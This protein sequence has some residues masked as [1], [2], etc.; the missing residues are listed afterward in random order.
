M[1][2]VTKGLALLPRL[3]CSGAITTHCSLNLLGSS[4]PPTSASHIA[5]MTEM[6]FHYVAQAGLKLLA[7]NDSPT[8]A[9][10]SAGITGV[11]HCASPMIAFITEMESCC[12]TQARGQWHD[13]S[14]QQPSGFRRFSCLR[15]LSSWDYRLERSDV[16]RAH[17]SLNLLGSSDPSTLAS[18]SLALSPRLEC[19]G[20]ISAHFNLGL[21]GPSDSLASA[22]RV[23]GITGVCHHACLIF[24]IFLAETGFCHV[25]QAGLELLTSSDLPALASESS[26]ITDGIY[27][28][29][30]RLECNGAILAYCNLCLTSLSDSPA[31]ASRIAG[32]IGTHHHVRLIFCICSRD[33]VSPCWPGWSQ[34]PPWPP[35]VLGLQV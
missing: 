35:K 23:A 11:S 18:R 10:Q 30:L 32:I 9:F 27:L 6:G 5:G 15:L 17:C 3:E 19:S 21:M 2:Q 22:S 14:S 4:K 34:T 7:S 25:D 13:L 24:V 26:E 28:L 20:T 16:I 8:L 29:L 12:V 31:S 1:L 33:G